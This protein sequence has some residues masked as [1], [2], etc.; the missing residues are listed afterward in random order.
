MRTMGSI[1]RIWSREFVK[2]GRKG[3]ASTETKKFMVINKKYDDRKNR[4]IFDLMELT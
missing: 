1:V 2:Y 3:I 4:M